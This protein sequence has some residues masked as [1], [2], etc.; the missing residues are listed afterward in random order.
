MT[1]INRPNFIYGDWV[2]PGALVF[3]AGRNLVP[4]KRSES[5]YSITGDVDF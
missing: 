1:E 2:K 3:D 5:G 4:N